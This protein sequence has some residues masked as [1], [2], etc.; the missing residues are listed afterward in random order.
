MTMLWTK[1]EDAIIQGLHEKGATSTE[2]SVVLGNKGYLRPPH[3][4]RARLSRLRAYSLIEEA[5]AIYDEEYLV[6]KEE[7]IFDTEWEKNFVIEERPK[8]LYFDI[9]TADLSAGFGEMLMMGY[10]WNDSPN[11]NLIAIYDYLGWDKLPIEQRDL[12]LVKEASKIISQADVLV[13]HY[14]TGFDHRFI[15]TRCIYH[16]LPPIPDTVHVDTWK[17]A[18]YQLRLHS[19]KLATLAEAL[20]CG[21][22][23]GS[24][25]LYLW[26]RSKA[27]DLH[28]L[29]EMAKYC[30]QDVRTQYDVTQKLMPIAR[31]LPNWNLLTGDMKYRCPACGSTKIA[32]RGYRYTKVNKY[33]RFQCNNCGHW[34]RGRKTLTD[35]HADR[36]MY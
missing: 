12:Y 22:R 1:K 32:K 24:L 26:R 18:K 14:S 7:D 31:K 27:H 8:I 3:A 6:S 33:Q 28:A 4:V 13:G 16:G 5:E 11:V 21:E 9:E 19:N 35:K 34:S 20:G 15:Q 10:R 29:K 25:P 2:I 23:K 17:I 30:K 36:H